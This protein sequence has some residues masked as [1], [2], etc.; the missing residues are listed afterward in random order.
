MRLIVLLIAGVCV[1]SA[2]QAKR[3]EAPLNSVAGADKRVEK[4]SLDTSLFDSRLQKAA[5]SVCRFKNIYDKFLKMILK[6]NGL[7]PVD[8]LLEVLDSSQQG[9][10]MEY[11][12][13]LKKEN[14]LELPFFKFDDPCRRVETLATDT[15]SKDIETLE[16]KV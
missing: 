13:N 1:L 9:M 4:Q 3:V 6:Q 7:T 10:V 11:D 16:V 8:I 2:C 15:K 12:G 14:I 5:L